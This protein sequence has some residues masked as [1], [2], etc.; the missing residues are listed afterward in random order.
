MAI[1]EVEHDR[2]G[3]SEHLTGLGHEGGNQ[4]TGIEGEELRV[5]MLVGGDVDPAQLVVETTFLEGEQRRSGARAVL[6][7]ERV[8]GDG[9][10]GTWRE[11]LLA[12][13]L[14][15]S[16]CRY[17]RT[18]T[19]AIAAYVGPVVDRYVSSLEGTLDEM[20]LRAPLRLMRSDGGV[21]TPA[22]VRTNPGHTLLSGPAGGVIAGAG[23]EGGG[24]GGRAS[25]V[26]NPDSN[27]TEALPTK[28]VGAADGE[29]RR[30]PVRE[31]RRR[32][33]GS[34]SATP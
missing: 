32:R 23:L 27:R 24:I 19:T 31:Q 17:P 33:L 2:G 20:Q 18:N 14:P 1:R 16:R 12:H 5:A 7:I 3:L 4:S 10:L 15:V 9:F 28:I 22:S 25:V 13:A 6:M 30:D 29:G 26:S 11:I 8:H 21:A 34:G